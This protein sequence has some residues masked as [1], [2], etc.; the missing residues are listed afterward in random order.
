[1]PVPSNEGRDPVPQLHSM[2]ETRFLSPF[3]PA[4][5]VPMRATGLRNDSIGSPI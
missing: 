3:L 2:P 5:V 4:R 1:M